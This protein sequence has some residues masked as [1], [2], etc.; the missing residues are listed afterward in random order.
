M[1]KFVLREM[2]SEDGSSVL[3]GDERKRDVFLKCS[4]I[5]NCDVV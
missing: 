4:I 1:E 3:V 5:S 2:T